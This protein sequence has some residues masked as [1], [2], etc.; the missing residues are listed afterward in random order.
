V[1]YTS[2]AR[3]LGLPLID[4]RFGGPGGRRGVARGW[5]AVGDVAFGPLLALGGLAVGG[6][7]LGGGAVGALAFGGVT[8]G[9][10]ALGGLALGWLALG[11]AAFALRAAEG[12]LA[13]ASAYALGGAARAPHANDAAATAYL[14]GHPYF[15]VARAV[16]DQIWVIVA[17][18]VVIAAAVIL[19]RRAR[20]RA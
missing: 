1:A 6:V 4:V 15:I 17:L 5:I 13:V 12:G 20:R 7:A 10:L 18:H 2:R 3:W 14:E 11:G 9:V 8:L 16:M 19:R